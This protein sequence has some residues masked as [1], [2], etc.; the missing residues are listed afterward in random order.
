[1][2]FAY[3]GYLKGNTNGT[4]YFPVAEDA[5]RDLRFNGKLVFHT[6]RAYLK[7]SSVWAPPRQMTIEVTEPEIENYAEIEAIFEKF[8]TSQF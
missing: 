6:N 8:R 3:F 2:R 5:K 1:M 7:A 4:W